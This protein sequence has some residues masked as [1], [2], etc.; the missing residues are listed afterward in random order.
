MKQ[1][2]SEFWKLQSEFRFIHISIYLVNFKH[3]H[4]ALYMIFLKFG[5][6]GFVRSSITDGKSDLEHFQSSKIG[7]DIKMQ[8]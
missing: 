5:T 1:E 7:P 4:F 8:K 2:L 6:Q 3:V